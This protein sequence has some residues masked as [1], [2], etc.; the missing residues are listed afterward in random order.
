MQIK[1]LNYRV[2]ELLS[3]NCQLSQENTMAK[4]TINNI[5][6][7]SNS[8]LTQS[9]TQFNQNN[10]IGF[11]ECDSSNL[12]DNLIAV[13]I[14]SNDSRINYPVVCKASTLF[15]DV[16]NKLY[17][18]HPEYMRYDGKDNLFLGNG[19]RLNK[20]ETMEENGFTGYSIVL[21]NN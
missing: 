3:F 9:F 21:M 13:N 4:N 17:Q 6:Y 20:L 19:N 8:Q 7:W 14:T 15:R 5:S 12:E 1:N 18:R 2:N 10:Q 16:E 11:V